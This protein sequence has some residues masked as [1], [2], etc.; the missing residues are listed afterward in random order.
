ME[1]VH[2]LETAISSLEGKCYGEEIYLCFVSQAL[3]QCLAQSK[4][5]VNDCLIK[6]LMEEETVFKFAT[7]YYTRTV[8]SN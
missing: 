5:S 7:I 4:Q 1:L 6:D 2:K 8:L 3:E